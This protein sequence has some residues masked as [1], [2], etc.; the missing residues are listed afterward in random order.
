MRHALGMA[1]VLGLSAPASAGA[2]DLFSVE[3]TP[4]RVELKLGAG[5]ATRRP[6]R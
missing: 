3:V 4:L 2:Q 1:L 6:S 5:A